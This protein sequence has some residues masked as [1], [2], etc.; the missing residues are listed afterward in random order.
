M[1]IKLE[2]PVKTCFRATEL[3]E[4]LVPQTSCVSVDRNPCDLIT[5]FHSKSFENLI[6]DVIMKKMNQMLSFEHDLQN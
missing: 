4:K 5:F 3:Y 1:K 2:N 6:V